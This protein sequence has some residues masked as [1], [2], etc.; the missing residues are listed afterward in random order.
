M[1]PHWNKKFSIKKAFLKNFL[2]NCWHYVHKW[3][4]PPNNSPVFLSERIGQGSL[5]KY[6]K[7]K[8]NF[9]RA[10]LLHHRLIKN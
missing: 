1:N 8:D 4:M 5:C 3:T 7:E 2:D 6:V 9:R 10:T